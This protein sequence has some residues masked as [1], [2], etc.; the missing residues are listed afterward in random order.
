M[1]YIKAG[2]KADRKSEF[3]VS[4]EGR[5]HSG[6]LVLGTLWALLLVSDRGLAQAASPL[7]KGEV[8]R[9][10]DAT[11][12]EF[13]GRK[14]WTYDVQ[15]V[16]DK[17]KVVLQLP[18]FDQATLTR[19]SAWQDELISKVEVDKRGPDGSYIVTFTLTEPDVE[20]FDYL[21]DDPSRLI[22]DFYRQIPAHQPVVVNT[23]KPAPPK[24]AVS[25]SK[26]KDTLGQY[27]QMT[28]PQRQ[29]A[30]VGLIQVD[31][32]GEEAGAGL[33]QMYGAFD[34][35]DP[36][37]DRFR[38]KD[39][40]IKEE[41]I[42]ASQQ[43]VYIRFPLLKMPSTRLSEVLSNSPE[44]VIR[45]RESRE[46]KEARLLLELYGRNR[47]NIFLKTFDYFMN[48]YPE[49][50]YDEILRQLAAELYFKKWK[51][52]SELADFEKAMTLY[53]YL[54]EKYPDS[55]LAERTQLIM[56]YAALDR[57]D[58]VTALQEIK[59]FKEKFP[60]SLEK[61]Y[62]ERAKAEALLTLSKYEEALSIYKN[63]ES[64]AKEP[65]MRAEASYRIGDVL[66][67]SGQ[68]LEAV[69]AYREA[70]KKYP[71]YEKIYPNAH[72]NLSEALFW[73]GKYQDSLDHAIQFISL[74]PS[75]EFG[76]YA[77]TRIG[78]ILDILGADKRRVMG[79]YL[80]SY[81]RY[82]D[83]PG[84][85]IARIRMLSQRMKGMKERELR[86]SIEEMRKIA[87][88]SNLPRASEFFI[89]MAADGLHI[90]GE[91][92]QANKML[93]EYY[94]KNPTSSNQQAIKDRVV[95]NITDILREYLEQKDFLTALNFYEKYSSTWLRSVDRVD[96]PYFIGLA[97]EQG[98]VFDR[99]QEIYQKIGKKIDQMANTLEGKTRNVHEH[100]PS[101]D[102]V[103]LRLAA[104]AIEQRAYNNANEFLKEIKEPHRLT[105]KEQVERIQLL[106]RV[107][108]ER[109]HL[110]EA[111]KHLNHLVEEWQSETRLLAP[112]LLRLARIELATGQESAAIRHV[113][114]VLNE[115]SL[116]DEDILAS[117][118]EVKGDG[119]MKLGQDLAAAK[120]YMELLDRFEDKRHLGGVR[121]KA[122]QILFDQGDLRGAEQVWAR[123]DP[124]RDALYK[125][126]ADERMDQVEWDETYKKYI[127][128]IPAMSG[129]RGG[130]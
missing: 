53:K 18:A 16:N 123:L 127:D 31:N 55:P 104:V 67:S 43:N 23:E 5:L 37:Y 99:S 125:K 20:T 106:A 73:R 19:L 88:E 42:I 111:K 116:I 107:A 80:E 38:I 74:F 17:N 82:R 54:V 29:P 50:D 8:S 36:N 78:E 34:G 101:R 122:G 64:S 72:I 103:S 90:R 4:H 27:Q 58:A 105:K 9:I 63:L 87:E 14:E 41:S 69:A 22:V 56:A 98:G 128:R 124:E 113:D 102:T 115:K 59:V 126:I 2:S 28:G 10:A 6:W 108:E 75:N 21:T 92:D 68:S 12:I 1:L 95:Q 39:Y 52:S 84:A 11:H 15:R 86:E 110:N 30:D 100:I 7:T 112:V 60:E 93:I 89:L 79:A 118:Y 109:G 70:L 24:K 32:Q 25:P 117:C 61:S 130:E 94:Q 77:M 44:Y 45:P 96:I 91:Y 85:K 65:S 66:Y 71:E 114:R 120:S 3:K 46:N 40:E 13:R 119:L 62:I 49:S 48:K 81:F 57:G 35:G 51:E 83:N 97:F 26:K 121:F 129:L 33:E 47:K 76:G